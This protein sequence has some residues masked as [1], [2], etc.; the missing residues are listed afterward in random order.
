LSIDRRVAARFPVIL[1]AEVT[2]LPL[3]TPRTGRTS[4]ISET[5]CFVDSLH[6]LSTGSRIRL[7]LTR[8]Y[9]SFET[10]ATVVYNPAQGMGIRFDD[11]VAPKQLAVL[12]K[13]IAVFKQQV[14]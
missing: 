6:P 10:T 1:V 8:G 13:W 11:P 2:E 3:G 12:H 7:R 14:A 4:D 9:E 5:G